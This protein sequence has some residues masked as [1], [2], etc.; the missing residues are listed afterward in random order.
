[1]IKFF[2]DSKNLIIFGL[3][4]KVLA[5]TF[6]ASYFLADLF[7][8][9]V[10]FF[11]LNLENPYAHFF[12]LNS[13]QS[14]PY[15]ALMLFFMSVP[16]FFAEFFFDLSSLPQQVSYF[17]YRLP[18]LIADMGILLILSSWAREESRKKLILL[19]WFSPVLFYISYIHG[20]LDVIPIFLLLLS[21]N[22]LIKQKI[23]LAGLIFG[24]ALSTKTM[25]LISLPFIILFLFSKDH[26]LKNILM[27][28][29]VASILFF[30]INL[31]FIFDHA[32]QEMVFN[33]SEQNRVFELSFP[34][35]ESSF[36][37]IPACLLIL[38]VRGI[39]IKTYSKDIFLMFLGFSF[40]IILMFV[41]PMQ[42][43]YF[44]LI[45]FLTYFYAKS[46]DNSFV[47]L[48]ILQASYLIYFALV[49]NSYYLNVFSLASANSGTIQQILIE[50]G[51]N[52][53][54][55]KGVAFTVLQVTLGVNCYF[56]YR[57]GIDSYSKHKI[58]STPYLVGVGGDSG[59]GKTT[60]AESLSNIFT[61]MNSMVI[62]GD[63][64]HKWQRGHEKW[65]EF[66]HLDPKANL[67]HQEIVMLNSL[68]SGKSILR[69]MY[70]HD[71]GTFSKDSLLSPKNL[72]IFEGLHPFYLNRQRQLY[73]VKIFID[74]D[75]NLSN[76]WKIKR[77]MEKRGYSKNKI[78]EV[79]SEREEDSL[80]FVK[81]QAKYSDILISPK[82]IKEIQDIG[83]SEEEIEIKYNI[84]MIN[85]IF[86]ESL[87]E[88]LN[89]LEG[90]SISH[91][92]TDEDR[93][94]IEV[95]GVASLEEISNI[96]KT[97]IPSLSD[98]GVDYPKWPHDSLGVIILILT[99]FIFEDA[100]YGKE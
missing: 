64:M 42:G 83:N 95:S 55:L 92:Y 80:N 65:E 19:Y 94:E 56:I 49:E 97:Y 40:G 91:K 22:Y 27:F 58:T 62:R 43:W 100:D 59:V 90:L 72:V 96:A 36:F 82:P 79:M 61:S 74:P 33:N 25:V 67:L 57:K 99:F 2:L 18:L 88:A 21:L 11:V 54:S 23:L 78:L 41:T 4:L 39:M 85:S 73:D 14:F 44:W 7:I 8:P 63:D 81:S 9:F 75:K 98:L 28:M 47:L 77:D 52:S 68:K 3:L 50:I 6:F 35:G 46:E 89:C 66:T 70:N 17:I 32:F 34:V 87:V 1:M 93:Q 76:H 16:V 84:L 48:L 37:F 15:P 13:P 30:G 5:G 69:K 31:P 71:D 29:L 45:P 51:I 24:L 12:E 86:L 20:Q 26:N 38:I 53:E 60:L 10:N